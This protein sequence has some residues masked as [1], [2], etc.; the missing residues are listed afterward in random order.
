MSAP[1]LPA[2]FTVLATLATAG[3]AGPALAFDS[4]GHSVIEALSYRTLVEG[5]GGQP[6]RPDVLR[7]LIN[8]GALDAPWCFGMGDRPPGEC[9]DA[10]AENPLLW[11]PQPEADRPDAFFRRQFSDAGQCFHYMGTITDGL[12]DPIPGT[13]VSASTARSVDS[14]VVDFESL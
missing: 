9:L 14:G 5:Y 4:K 1:R 2:A 8:D 7:D 3:V 12:A 6:P 13:S 11:W 10:P